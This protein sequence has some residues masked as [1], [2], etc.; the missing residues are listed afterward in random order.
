MD[1]EETR[2]WSVLGK[3]NR[4]REKGLLE[5]GWM[6]RKAGK[7]KQSFINY[8]SIGNAR[9]RDSWKRIIVKMNKYIYIYHILQLSLNTSFHFN[10]ILS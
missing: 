6:E 8:S 5:R 2:E 7:E 10:T 1:E 3:N 9:P 4:S